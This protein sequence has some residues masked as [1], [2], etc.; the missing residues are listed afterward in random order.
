ML[1]RLPTVLAKLIVH[2]FTRPR[3]LVVQAWLWLAAKSQGSEA[4]HRC[5]NAALRLDTDNEP[6]ALALLFLDQKR[7]ES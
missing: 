1:E 3:P 2:H 7:P 5:L 6:A 4:K